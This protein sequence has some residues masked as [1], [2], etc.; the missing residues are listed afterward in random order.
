MT[1]ARKQTL[2]AIA[3]KHQLCGTL[4]R[5]NSDR[6]DFQECAVWNIEAALQEAYQKGFTVG[7]QEQI[8]AEKTKGIVSVQL[9]KLILKSDKL[10]SHR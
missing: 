3:R 1:K 5:R 10:K 6:L 9:R 8:M 2:E 4:K 7:Q